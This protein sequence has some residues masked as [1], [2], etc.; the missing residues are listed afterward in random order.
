MLAGFV[1][2]Q[3]EL[4]L[5][6]FVTQQ[7]AFAPSAPRTWEQLTAVRLEFMRIPERAKPFSV[8]DPPSYGAISPLGASQVD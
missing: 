3:L 8:V 1:T 6:G 7:L 5:A 2:Q 4:M